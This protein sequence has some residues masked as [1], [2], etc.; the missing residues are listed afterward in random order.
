LTASSRGKYDARVLRAVALSS[1]GAVFQPRQTEEVRFMT[2]TT[3]R[4]AAL[5]AWAAAF[6]C[7]AAQARASGFAIFEQG[8]K[9]MGFAGAFTAQS[10][11]SSIFHNAA[12]IAFLK[13]KHLHLGG[14]LIS[15]R[16]DFTGADPFPGASVIESSD[17]GLLPVPVGDFTWQVSEPMVLGL[18]IHVPFGLETRW[19]NPGSYTGRFISKEAKL[20]GFSIN[21]TVAYKLADRFAIGGGVDVR[22]AKV[23]LQRNVS[24]INPF[25]QQVADI[26]AVE[27]ASGY[28]TGFGFNLGVLAKPN[29]AVSLG[30]SYRHKVKVE[31]DGTASFTRIPTGNAQLDLLA[32][33]ALP[34]AE[35]PL[36]TEIEFPAIASVGVAWSSG[37][38]TVEG[39][40]NWYQW[41][42]FDTLPLTFPEEP[43]LSGTIQ[44]LYENSWQFRFGLERVLNDSWAVRGGYFYDQSPSPPESVGPLLPDADRHGAALGASWT[45]ARLRLD[46]AYWHLFI[47]ERSSEGLNRDAYNG[48]YSNR[49]DLFALSL[50]LGF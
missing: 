43:Q 19:E 31:F 8:A 22:F 39:D 37:D 30:F 50:N 35:T 15:P 44:E 13:G 25:T 38:W 48:T 34:G 24:A 29:D 9:G 20:Q 2:T 3:R 18:G 16:G 46:F 47:K 26:A 6:A 41:S 36:T 10:D 32:V 1:T 7:A 45:H 4:R 42:S 14:T 12:G 49:A 40:A 28:E 21:P 11:A 23:S 33:R 27:L 17:V 5:A